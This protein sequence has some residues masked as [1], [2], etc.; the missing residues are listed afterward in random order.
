MLL[1][2]SDLVDSGPGHE[3]SCPVTEAE[4]DSSHEASR[5]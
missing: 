1:F 2:Q 5:G 4:P 3:A